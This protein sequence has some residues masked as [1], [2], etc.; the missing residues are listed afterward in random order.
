MTC[1]TRQ[2]VGK[3]TYLYESTSY[4]DELGR[5]RNKKVRIG[6]LD[7]ETG[8]PIYDPEYLARKDSAGNTDF[9]SQKDESNC[10]KL[11]GQQKELIHEALDST[12]S[13]GVYYLFN[14]LSKEVNLIETIKKSFPSLYKEIFTLACFLI[15]SQ[16]PC[17]Y[18]GQWITQHYTMQGV[19]SMD[20]Q[21][22]SNLLSEMTMS[23]RDRF[24][25]NWNKNINNSDFVALDITSISSYSELIEG[26]DWGYNR[27]GEKLPQINLCILF[28]EGC[29][30]P[31][32]L[33]TYNG[34]ISDVSTLKTTIKEMT[35]VVPNAK[36]KA[37]MDKGF[38][39]QAN[40]DNM[41]EENVDF[42]ISV[43]FTNKFAK[44]QIENEREDIDTYKN[45]IKAGNDPL[46]GIHKEEEWKTKRVSTKLHVHVFYNPS[47]HTKE[48]NE[49]FD[50]VYDLEEEA[51]KNPEN[52]N[53]EKEF[54]KYLIIEKPS[55]ENPNYTV[56]VRQDYLDEKLKNC[57][58]MLLI[59][60][61]ISD[62]RQALNIYRTKDIVEKCFNKLKNSLDFKRL[63]VHND[64]RMENKIFIGFIC[65]IIIS[66]LHQKMSSANLYKTYTM[67]ELILELKKLKI[68]TVSGE[69]ILQ[70]VSKTQRDIF[71]SL[72][73]P[74]PAVG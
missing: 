31:I 36:I 18:C 52:K 68:T 15:E 45:Y 73:I 30:Y 13:Y 43:P 34:K 38:Y 49:L 62:A 4:R 72:S 42:I 69:E 58:W 60:N 74:L 19:S 27:D 3:H 1:I 21:R 59:S 47:R 28:G 56:S 51:K 7:L 35:N 64:E 10:G 57:G 41:I 11:S 5:P 66:V 25:D 6:K 26:V 2:H 37:S 8:E 63:R 14:E 61:T 29:Q 20:S 39:S 46:R 12:K 48:K 53:F 17:M 22:I 67:K 65:V 9:T 55:E 50:F 40:V 70:P 44:Q 16:D 23:E 71:N 24:Y 32:F 54:E 33:K